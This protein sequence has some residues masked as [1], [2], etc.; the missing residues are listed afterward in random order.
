M[1]KNDELNKDEQGKRNKLKKEKPYVYKKSL[2]LINKA[3]KG[4]SIANILLQYSYVCNFRCVHCCITTLR[5]RE[6]RKSFNP[7]RVKNLADQADEMGLSRFVISGGEPILFKDLDSIVEA[8]G[9]DRFYINFD[10]N[11][12]ILDED[13]LRHLKEIGI[14]RIQLSIDNLK[15]DEHDAFRR[16]PGAHQRA[17]DLIDPILQAGLDIF[18]QTVVTKQRIHSEEFTDFLGFFNSRGV[19]VFVNYP[20]PVGEWQG[21][22]DI[23]IDKEDINYMASLETRYKVFTH[24]TP[25]YG[26]DLGCV[27]VKGMLTITAYG[28][29]MPCPWIHVSLGNVFEEPLYK[30]IQR[31]LG[32]KYFGEH[33][34]TCLMAEDREFIRKYIVGRV[35]GGP[36]PVLYSEVF[37]DDDKTRVAFNEY[38]G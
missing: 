2:N 33:I 18:V 32:I 4:E 14:D 29:V 26:I 35:Y 12:S 30:I 3:Q 31:G 37:G 25:H 19:G 10:S 15:S 36:A 6:Y 8:I 9:P 16:T 13:K 38:Q 22:L 20:K 24:L 28:D 11:G 34:N 21:N 5:N 17:M 7:E 27:A 23:L 1:D